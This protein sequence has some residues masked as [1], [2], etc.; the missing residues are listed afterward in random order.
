M[1][2]S[3]LY[4]TRSRTYEETINADTSTNCNFTEEISKLRI[5][6]V[7]NFHDLWDEFINIKNTIIKKL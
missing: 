2:Q 4:P 3:H 7:G 5:D 1:S 6:L